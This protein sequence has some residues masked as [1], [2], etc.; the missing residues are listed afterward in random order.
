M[1]KK[2]IIILLF[3][4][5][6][7]MITPI[8]YSQFKSNGD[9]TGAIQGA[10]WSVAINGS[11]DNIN[12]TSGK[13][14]IPYTLTLTNSSEVDVTYSIILTNLP[15]GIAA[16]LD[17][18]SYVEEENNQIVFNNAGNISYNSVPINRI[19]TF[20]ALLDADEVSQHDFN[21]D[22]EFKQKLN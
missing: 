11:N 2:I 18:G 3:F 4:I 19:I 15:E 17:G 16:K 8:T 20:K 14:E 22:V 5:L 7:I 12:L 10:S 21:I 1:N 6:C 13:T 9:A